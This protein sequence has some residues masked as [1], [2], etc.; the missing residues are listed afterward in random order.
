MP[1]VRLAPHALASAVAHA[2]R[3]CPRECCGLLLGQNFPSESLRLVIDQAIAVRNIDLRP[4]RFEIDALELARVEFDSR[5][6]DLCVLGYYHSHPRGDLSPS[7]ADETGVILADLPPFL[8]L[9]VAAD[10]RCRLFSTNTRPW[11]EVPF[12]V[13]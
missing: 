2:R 11:S 3:E 10:G 7:G 13:T 5:K 12:R 1:D 4:E 6:A 9:I 8:H